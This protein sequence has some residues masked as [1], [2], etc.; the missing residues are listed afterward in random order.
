MRNALLI[1]LAVMTGAFIIFW[2]FAI[3]DSA[4]GAE[5]RRFGPLQNVIG[6]VVNF[7]DTLGIGSFATATASYKL[8]KLVRDEQL[9]GTLNVGNTIPSILQA[10]IYIDAVKVGMTTLVTLLLASVLGAWLGAR[11][12]SR[13]PRRR[14]QIG[15]SIAL[16]MASVVMLMTQFSLLPPGGDSLSLSAPKLIVAAAANFTFSGLMMMGIGFYAP[17]MMVVSLLGMDPRAAFP[18]MMGSCAF[19]MPVG[20]VPFIRARSYDMKAAIGLTVGGVPAV[21]LAAYLVRSLPLGA[22][23]WLVIVVVIYTATMMLRSAMVRAQ[24]IR[25]ESLAAGGSRS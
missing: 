23:R 15:M 22:V 17:C 9:P 5:K 6:F 7:F 11:M 16:F 14:I 10:F 1:T 12:V 24:A 18:I 8:F 2:L 20:S 4:T 13:W 21:L 3:R 25:P 19:M